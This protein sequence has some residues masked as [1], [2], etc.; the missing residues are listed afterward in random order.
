MFGSGEPTR[1]AARAAPQRSTWIPTEPAA[2]A[3]KPAFVGDPG[4]RSSG[5]TSGLAAI[6]DGAPGAH[7]AYH[8]ESC[9]ST[10][11]THGAPSPSES[12]NGVGAA[13]AFASSFVASGTLG[14]P[15]VPSCPPSISTSPARSR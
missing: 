9:A 15:N 10:P 7:D 4:G 14:V 1:A 3:K 5:G 12:S 6:A 11:N 2:K 8:A 13:L